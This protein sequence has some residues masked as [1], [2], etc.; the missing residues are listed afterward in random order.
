MAPRVPIRDLATIRAHHDGLAGAALAAELIRAASRTSAAIGAATGAIVAAGE[1]APPSWVVIPFELAAETLLIALVEVK[2]IAEL[3]EV[4]GH[5]VAG[6]S[7]A[8]A[9]ALLRAWAERR[10][11]T[12]A[13]LA[14]PGGV[15]DALGRGTRNELARLLRRRLAGRMGRNLSTLA[16]LLTGAVAGAEINRRATRSLGESV[17]RDLAA[18]GR[19]EPTAL[20]PVPSPAG[21]LGPGIT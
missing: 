12:A 15:A 8:R 18:R 17:I 10:G 13:M 19:S 4:F 2:L 9:G 6:D 3:H 20:P 5:P 7:G 1:L 11:V 21:E 16:P 14:Q